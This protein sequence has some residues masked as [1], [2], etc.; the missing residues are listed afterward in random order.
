MQITGKGRL[1]SGADPF[2]C[3]TLEGYG[4]TLDELAG[5]LNAR[6]KKG[7]AAARKTAHAHERIAPPR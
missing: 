6:M 3:E 5:E 2:F 7:R 4:V 1:P